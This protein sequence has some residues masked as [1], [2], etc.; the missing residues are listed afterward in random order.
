MSWNMN[1][2]QRIQETAISENFHAEARVA[3]IVA[4][5]LGDSLIEFP[6]FSTVDRLLVT[7]GLAIAWLEVKTRT[8]PLATYPTY[9]I[10]R[11]KL[12]ALRGLEYETEIPALV[13][14]E[15]GCGSIGVVKAS[16]VYWNL[17]TYSEEIAIKHIPLLVGARA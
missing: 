10:D 14:I 2:A 17:G 15:W 1:G 6:R 5:T 9:R 3:Q 16:S 13:A 7:N 11:A 4:D 12:V 8:T